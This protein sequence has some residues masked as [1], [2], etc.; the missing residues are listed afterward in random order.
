MSGTIS[1]KPCGLLCLYLRDWFR[2]IGQKGKKVSI[3]LPFGI[4]SAGRTI[5]VGGDWP[6]IAARSDGNPAGVLPNAHLII[7][8]TPL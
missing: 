6:C 4:V 3:F 1:D 8:L 5:S 2:K 7:N